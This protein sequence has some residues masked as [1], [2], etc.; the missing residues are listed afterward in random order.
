[1]FAIGIIAIVALANGLD[2]PW[3]TVLPQHL[4]AF[5]LGMLLAVLSAHRWSADTSARLARVGRPTWV[6]WSVALLA[7]LAIPFVLGLDPLEAPSTAQAI[8]LNLCQMIVGI[9]VVVPVVLGPQDQG[10]IRRVLRSPPAVYLGLVSYGIYLWH[11]YLLRIVADWLDWP[12]YQG[13]WLAVLVLAL[14]IVIVAASV[15]W[16]AVERPILRLAHRVA[17][18]TRRSNE[19]RARDRHALH[20]A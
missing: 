13:N 14:P 3:V 11:W 4:G 8:G 5:A 20:D 12:L 9:C 18:G 16:F 10:I 17:P 19:P 1:L 7:L 15:S 2:A 6:W